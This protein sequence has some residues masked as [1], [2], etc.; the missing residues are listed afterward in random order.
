M[1]MIKG[2]APGA[3][4]SEMWAT[5]RDNPRLA[6]PIMP[7][8]FAPMPPSRAHLKRLAPRK[9]FVEVVPPTPRTE[10]HEKNRQI[11]EFHQHVM[12]GLG[13]TRTIVASAP[14]VKPR[15]YIEPTRELDRREHKP[16]NHKLRDHV[17]ALRK[18]V[19]VDH[20]EDWI[21]NMEAGLL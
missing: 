2:G 15:V 4:L 9:P 10:Q 3:S 5:I 18:R 8:D 1:K 19:Y 13:G 16:V 12:A 11:M 20:Q 6:A 14:P 21:Q 7:S 17:E